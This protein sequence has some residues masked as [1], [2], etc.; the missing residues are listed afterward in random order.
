MVFG[1]DNPSALSGLSEPVFVLGIRGKVVVV[2]VECG[3][4]LTERC[5]DTVLPQRA[6]EEEDGHFRRLRRRVRT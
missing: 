6:I 3:T 1:Q 4:G 5:G 2:D